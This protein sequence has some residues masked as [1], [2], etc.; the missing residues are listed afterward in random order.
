MTLKN[1]FFQRLSWRINPGTVGGIQKA[2]EVRTLESKCHDITEREA[3]NPQSAESSG[4]PSG[5]QRQLRK[6]LKRETISL[7]SM[8][9]AALVTNQLDFIV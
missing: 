4:G 6:K 8:G 2:E 5:Q 1:F 9:L 7:E 3:D